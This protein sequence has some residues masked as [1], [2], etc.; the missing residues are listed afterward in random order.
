MKSEGNGSVHGV[1]H[2]TLHFAKQPCARIRSLT[3]NAFDA[4]DTFDTCEL[5]KLE[6]C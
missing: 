1:G 6:Q 2:F 5:H 3:C 4:F